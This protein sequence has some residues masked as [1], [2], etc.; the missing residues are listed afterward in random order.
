MSTTNPDPGRPRADTVGGLTSTPHGSPHAD[1]H[2][3]SGPP[4]AATIARGHEVDRYDAM[5]VFSV[6]LLVVLFFVLAFGT[7]SVIFYFIAPSTADP[8]ATP[9]GD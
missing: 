5:S 8:T 7:V 1:D 9:A 6:P 2:D 4:D 3:I